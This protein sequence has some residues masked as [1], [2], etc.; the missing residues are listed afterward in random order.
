MRILLSASDF[1]NTTNGLA[2]SARD[3]CA[4]LRAQNMDFYLAGSGPLE[5][6]LHKLAVPL[7]TKVRIGFIPHNELITLLD[8]ADIY[9][10]CALVEIEGLAALEAMTRDCMPIL[11]RSAQSS[12]WRYSLDS[13]KVFN[14]HYPTQ[15]ASVID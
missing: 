14:A 9:D 11:A 8:R 5:H 7:A 1:T 13:R 3:F 4:G 15:L 2:R 12:T 6:A 10:H